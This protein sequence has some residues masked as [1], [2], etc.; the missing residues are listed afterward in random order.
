MYEN[1]YLNIQIISCYQNY[2]NGLLYI[3]ITNIHPRKV[4]FLKTLLMLLV[5]SF[6]LNDGCKVFFDFFSTTY[7]LTVLGIMFYR[8]RTIQI[9]NK[10][11]L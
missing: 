6:I 1:M 11:L 3:F 5:I 9:R 4:Y 7:M 8:A 10:L 2:I